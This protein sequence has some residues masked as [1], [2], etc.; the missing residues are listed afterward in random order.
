MLIYTCGKNNNKKKISLFFSCL[1]LQ[2]SQ[3]NFFFKYYGEE[4]NRI[5]NNST[6]FLVGDKNYF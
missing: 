6:L 4:L 2:R 1:S 3:R 5:F